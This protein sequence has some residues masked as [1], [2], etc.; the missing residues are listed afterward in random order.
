[1]Q[2]VTKQ[3]KKNPSSNVITFTKLIFRSNQLPKADI[4]VSSMFDEY[5][6]SW[7]SLLSYSKIKC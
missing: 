4:V 1:M 6:F 7:I 5:K 2:R 3:T